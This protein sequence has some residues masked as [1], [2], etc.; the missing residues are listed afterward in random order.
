MEGAL[1]R[2]QCEDRGIGSGHGVKA[3][4]LNPDCVGHQGLCSQV[5]LSDL[6]RSSLLLVSAEET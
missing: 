2:V 6:D 5:P 4:R 3:G 1:C